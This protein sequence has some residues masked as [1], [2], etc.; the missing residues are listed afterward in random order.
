VDNASLYR[1]AQQALFTAQKAITSRD[2]LIAI[3]SHDLKNPLNAIGLSASN[4]L[5]AL[6]S[7]SHSANKM[8]RLISDLLDIA[9]I[10]A[11]NLS[12]RRE[13]C[14]V[15]RIVDQ[16]FEMLEPAATAKGIKVRRE[17]H[18]GLPMVDVDPSRIEQ[19][20]S[21]LFAN[22]VKFT[23][24]GGSITIGAERHGDDVCFVVADTGPGIPPE[25]FE[26]VFDRHWQA[27][28]TAH[29]GTGLGLSISKGIIESHGGQIW[30][31]SNPG[32]GSS[33]Y[34]TVPIVKDYV[35][36][37]QDSEIHAYH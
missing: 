29:L 3:V 25:H 18:S 15:S 21:N 9:S 7:I 13:A 23:P 12:I 27:R 5:R 1:E 34:F 6:D 8:N 11:R 35:S 30:V 19:V 26:H 22:S 20:L 4:G 24:N 31:T 16:V 28:E 10:D 33:F 36:A 14:D 2:E 37:P 32:E 17:V